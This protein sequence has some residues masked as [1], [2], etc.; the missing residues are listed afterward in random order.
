MIGEQE[1]AQGRYSLSCTDNFS[2]HFFKRISPAGRGSLWFRPGKVI[3]LA[4]LVCMA[5]P[6]NSVGNIFG[7]PEKP[8]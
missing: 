4:E 2:S 1:K 7:Q 5:I 8:E 3:Q 6:T